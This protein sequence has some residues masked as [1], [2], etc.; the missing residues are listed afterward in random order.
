ML[1]WDILFSFSPII[2]REFH[3]FLRE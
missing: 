1:V 2:P 3:P